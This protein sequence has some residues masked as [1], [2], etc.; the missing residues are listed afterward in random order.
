M[1]KS[2]EHNAAAIL[3]RERV[4]LSK[5]W[6]LQ[7]LPNTHQLGFWGGPKNETVRYVRWPADYCVPGSWHEAPNFRSWLLVQLT[8]QLPPEVWK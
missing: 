2:D 6:S 7:F 1:E 4:L 8:L 5:G 3:D